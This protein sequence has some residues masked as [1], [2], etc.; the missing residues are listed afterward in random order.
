MRLLDGELRQIAIFSCPVVPS[1][2]G[3]MKLQDY[4]LDCCGTQLLSQSI[5]YKDYKLFFMRPS[6]MQEWAL[7][8]ST[9]G[10]KHGSLSKLKI[11]F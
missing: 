3:Y 6:L 5:S 8:C 11:Y 4:C 10:K 1:T 9:V 2:R 7:Q